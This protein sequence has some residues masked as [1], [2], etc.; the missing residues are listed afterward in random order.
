MK[1]NGSK[2]SIS[3]PRTF[4]FTPLIKT[5]TITRRLSGLRTA[6]MLIQSILPDKRNARQETAR[7]LQNELLFPTDHDISSY[8]TPLLTSFSSSSATERLITG[9]LKY[10]RPLGIYCG[11]IPIYMS[12]QR[13]VDIN[14]ANLLTKG[15]TNRRITSCHSDFC[16]SYISAYRICPFCSKE[17]IAG[18][19]YRVRE[20]K[21]LLNCY[22]QTNLS[23]LDTD[24]V[25]LQKQDSHQ[26]TMNVTG[27]YKRNWF[28]YFVLFISSGESPIDIIETA[29]SLFVKN[30]YQRSS[31]T[32]IRVLYTLM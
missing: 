8:R 17:P 29:T 25:V 14:V 26:A 15:M 30:I 7:M 4:R 23:I 18:L 11:L 12:G 2:K 27:S 13:I 31:A 28:K 16:T 1:K 9:S 19:V 3:R 22:K 10:L 20:W 21:Q 5:G 6:V 24:R 32:R